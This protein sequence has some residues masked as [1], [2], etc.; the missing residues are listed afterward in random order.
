[1]NKRSVK[2]VRLM[3]FVVMILIILVFVSLMMIIYNK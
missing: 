2:T 1:M 3:E